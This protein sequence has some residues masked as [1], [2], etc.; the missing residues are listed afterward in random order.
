MLCLNKGHSNRGAD[1]DEEEETVQPRAKT[2]NS[3][4]ASG[5]EDHGVGSMRQA[6]LNTGL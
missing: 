3:A 1:H 5:G 4:R 2:L 6:R